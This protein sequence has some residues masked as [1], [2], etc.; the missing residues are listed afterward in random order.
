MMIIHIEG[1]K[2]DSYEM[3]SLPVK[4]PNL[5]GGDRN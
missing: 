1:S 4:E 5:L 3:S 2:Y